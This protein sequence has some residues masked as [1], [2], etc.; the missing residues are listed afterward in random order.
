MSYTFLDATGVTQTADSS[1][2]SGATQ[3]PIVNVASILSNIPVTIAGGSV[4]GS[5]TKD[6]ATAATDKGIFHLGVRNDTLS[7]VTS[8]DLNYSPISTGPA[9]ETITANAPLTKWVQGNASMLGGAPVNGS[10]VLVIAAQGASVFTYITGV[11]ITNASANNVFIRFDGG[12]SSIVG[13][14]IAPANGGSNITFPNGWKT[15]ANAAFTASVSGVS[16][17]YVSAQ[18]FISKT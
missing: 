2:V 6:S 18:G 10:S 4:A 12:T 3:R 14:T 7:S 13:Y 9:G 15:N 5:Y 11:Q 16:S 17:V 1:V 8:A